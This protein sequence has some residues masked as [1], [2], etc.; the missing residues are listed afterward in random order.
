LKAAILTIGTEVVDGEIVN[1]N[2]SWLATE[3]SELGL[4]VSHHLST[5]DDPQD[6]F[7]AMSWLEKKVDWL[8]IT[9]GLG[10]T[11]DDK[12]REVVSRFLGEELQFSPQVWSELT[13]AYFERGIRVTENHRHQCYFPKSAQRLKN[14]VGS[15]L[16]FRARKNNRLEVVVLPG[17]PRELHGVFQQELR[18]ELKSLDLDKAQLKSWILL[19]VT[20]SAA[21][22]KA[23][24]LFQEADVE[25]GYRASVPY[26]HVKAWFENPQEIPVYEDKMQTVF[27]EAI[28]AKDGRDPLENLFDQL[29]PQTGKSIL[30]QDL[31]SSGYLMTRLM[32]LE[33]YRHHKISLFSGDVP[34]EMQA[35]VV[36][37]LEVRDQSVIA[38]CTV[39]Q[40]VVEQALQMPYKVNLDSVRAQR[41]FT[42]LAFQSW[43]KVLGHY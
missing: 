2:A 6:M 16:G 19:G 4:K 34:P 11:T 26:V 24:E 3:L 20:E 23:E 35:D 36:L 18:A 15:A 27:G 1:T 8:F 7:E 37:R 39:K 38:T 33:T 43:A 40:E 12:T 21:A 9:G 41:Y 13:D 42:E 14:P 32:A 28:V 25:L 17:P 30:V 29:L 10:P 31:F 22:E 5:A